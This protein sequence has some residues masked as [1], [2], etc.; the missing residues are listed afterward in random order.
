MLKV[1]YRLFFYINFIGRLFT[2][3]QADVVSHLALQ[4]DIGHQAVAGFRVDT[5]QVAS[6][7]VAVWIA[8]LYIKQQNKFIRK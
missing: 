7:R 1:Q 6:V 2:M 5:W 4:A 3:H 8:I